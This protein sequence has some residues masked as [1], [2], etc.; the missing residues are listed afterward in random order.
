MRNTRY[1]EVAERI[2]RAM[3]GG[4]ERYPFPKLPWTQTGFATPNVYVAWCPMADGGHLWSSLGRPHHRAD[5]REGEIACPEHDD[6]M[7]PASES[8]E[9]ADGWKH[10]GAIADPYDT[11]NDGVP[12]A[13][14]A[15]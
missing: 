9:Q 10:M 5:Q 2:R 4:E 12:S 1:D 6:E 8:P 3:A 14:C 11:D 13:G 7:A 15:W